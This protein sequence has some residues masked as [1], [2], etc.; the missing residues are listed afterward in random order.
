M[1]HQREP[2]LLEGR[3]RSE[4]NETKRK[5]ATATPWLIESEHV[6]SPTLQA[7]EEPRHREEDRPNHEG[8]T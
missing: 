4:R 8:S 7:K 6:K 1:G 5:L 2:D 3:G